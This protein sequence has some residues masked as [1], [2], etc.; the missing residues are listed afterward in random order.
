MSYIRYVLNNPKHKGIQNIDIE[1]IDA[2]YVDTWKQILKSVC[3]DLNFNW[4]LE[5]QGQSANDYQAFDFLYN[6][7]R[8]LVLLVELKTAYE[9][10]GKIENTGS[11]VWP[12]PDAFFDETLIVI[13]E[14]IQDPQRFSQDHLNVWHRQFT[15]LE[16]RNSAY[17]LYN[18]NED[19]KKHYFY[20]QEI[21]RIVHKLELFTYPKLPRIMKYYD[22]QFGI[23]FTNANNNALI[24]ND[25][26][27]KVWE[28]CTDLSTGIFDFET[29]K[30]DYDVWLQ[31]DILGKDHVKAWVEQDDLT[32]SDIT[33][34]LILTPS[35]M[36]DVN[37]I[38]KRVYD[39]KDFRKESKASGK[40]VDRLP[41]GNIVKPCGLN[42]MAGPI[43]VQAI[44]LDND[45][46]WENY[47]Q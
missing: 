10:L 44:L 21:N 14:L 11:S 15:T 3:T 26:C 6:V 42:E 46:I 28:Y 2:E 30:Y 4:I 35:L 36:L 47:E 38:I 29:D 13:N 34:N 37:K 33:G 43:T 1:L 23:Q 27:A 17:H 22:K 18:G 41:L 31:A 16:M 7:D 39:D 24:K 8:L 9:Y 12:E 19:N 32:Q 25:D 5:R 45:I 20:I 40:T